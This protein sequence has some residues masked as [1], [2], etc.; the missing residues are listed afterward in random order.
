MSSLEDFLPQPISNGFDGEFERKNK[1][2]LEIGASINREQ[3]LLYILSHTVVN[4]K[5][6]MQSREI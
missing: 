3:D 6:K 5:L 2:L 1:S 4:S